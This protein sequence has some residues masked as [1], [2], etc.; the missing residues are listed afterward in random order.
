MSQKIDA[1]QPAVTMN[2]D[3]PKTWADLRVGHAFGAV[4]LAFS[5]LL[6]SFSGVCG[7]MAGACGLIAGGSSLVVTVLQSKRIPLKRGLPIIAASVCFGLLAG[8]G[9]DVQNSFNDAA[10]QK[11]NDVEYH[12]TPRLASEATVEIK[13]S[14]LCDAT[15]PSLGPKLALS[16]K[17]TYR[18]ITQANGTKALIPCPR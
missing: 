8:A 1:A 6:M 7:T 11:A 10:Q 9:R 2:S 18:Q 16:D 3:I 5:P 17:K 12:A 15:A 14:E 4:L 13:A